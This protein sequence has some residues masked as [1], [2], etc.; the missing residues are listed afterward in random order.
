MLTTVNHGSAQWTWLERSKQPF[1]IEVLRSDGVDITVIFVPPGGNTQNLPSL[2]RPP[3]FPSPSNTYAIFPVVA[4]VDLACHA[5]AGGV[6][7]PWRHTTGTLVTCKALFGEVE[8]VQMLG[9][10]H[11]RIPMR[12]ATRTQ[13]TDTEL[14]Y[15]GGPPRV[16]G[17]VGLP[18][19]GGAALL[20]VALK[21][22]AP[23]L[24]TGGL[25]RGF[26]QDATGYEGSP[27]MLRIS[28][29]RTRAETLLISREEEEERARAERARLAVLA[30]KD[31]EEG[32]KP[33][34]WTSPEGGVEALRAGVGGLDDQVRQIVR[35]AFLTRTLPPGTMR[36]THAAVPP[37][38]P[39]P[40]CT[41]T[42]FHPHFLRNSSPC[43]QVSGD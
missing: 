35:R 43:F 16:V 12:Q 41:M 42:G 25:M 39:V 26:V 27:P 4:L 17:H 32:N 33:A 19:E 40:C 15:L 20:E 31:A 3:N 21:S 11:G 10:P 7:L 38:R 9:D 23:M 5:F 18:G 2:P 13:V 37:A 22:K 30:A 8:L 6:T 34:W 36:Y 29:P 28:I 14:R 24:G 1:Y